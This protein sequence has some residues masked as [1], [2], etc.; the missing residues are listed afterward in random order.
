MSYEIVKA[1]IHLGRVMQVHVIAENL[2]WLREA[3][4]DLIERYNGRSADI[5]INHGFL[6]AYDQGRPVGYNTA[7]NPVTL[8]RWID[9]DVGIISDG[10]S[11]YKSNGTPINATI[12]VNKG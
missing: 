9:T 3:E 7:R 11:E 2:R 12:L 10:N 5:T 6:V 1:P 4:L 8:K